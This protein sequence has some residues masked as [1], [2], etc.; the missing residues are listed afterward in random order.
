MKALLLLSI[1]GGV[2]GQVPSGMLHCNTAK[3]MRLVFDDNFP[4]FLHTCK[5]LLLI[6]IAVRSAL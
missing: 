2:L 3:Q 4:S 6:R 5:L 1:V